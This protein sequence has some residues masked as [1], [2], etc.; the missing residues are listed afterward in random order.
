LGQHLGLKAAHLAGGG[1]L[2][3]HGPTTN[4]PAHR[5]IV[6]Q[7]VSIVHVLVSGEPTE[8][9]L[10]DLRRQGMATVAAGPGV[11]ESLPGTFRQAEGIVEFPE[12]EQ[13][14]V[15]GDFGAVELQLQAAV[16]AEPKAGLWRFTRWVFHPRAPA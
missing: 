8:D 1:G 13:T 7:P 2:L 16:E 15:G 6:R 10:P 12:G 14:S 9:G 11:G 4:D 5:R 3:G